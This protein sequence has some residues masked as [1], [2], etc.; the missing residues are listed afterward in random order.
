MA[1]QTDQ[2]GNAST[3]VSGK[4]SNEIPLRGQDGVHVSVDAEK[5]K[6]KHDHSYAMQAPPYVIYPTYE[7]NS[8]N[9]N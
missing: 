8:F 7:D 6:V 3:S 9:A 5:S 4:T 1:I 2:T